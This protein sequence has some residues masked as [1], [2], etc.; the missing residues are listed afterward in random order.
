MLNLLTFHIDKNHSVLEVTQLTF[1]VFLNITKNSII[2]LLQL[3]LI[4]L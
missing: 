2:L 1:Y 3:R 4:I